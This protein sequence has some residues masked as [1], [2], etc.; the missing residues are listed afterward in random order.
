MAWTEEEMQRAELTHAPE[1]LKG[2]TYRLSIEGQ[3]GKPGKR[4]DVPGWMVGDP[5]GAQER[6]NAARVIRERL[7]RN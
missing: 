5:Q 6:M 2:D 7:F 4:I 1:R 3:D